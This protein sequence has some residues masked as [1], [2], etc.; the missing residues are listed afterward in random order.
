MA[1]QS[2]WIVNTTDDTFEADVFARSELGLVVVDFWAEWCAPCRMLGPVLEQLAID[3][4]GR[5]TLVKADTDQNQAAAG[6]FGVSGIP[7]VFAVLDRQVVDSF[8]GAL[9]P[10]AVK[11]WLESLETVATLVEANR[12]AHDDPHAAEQKIRGIL[13]TSPDFAPALIALA[14][15]L[16]GQDR[17]D[18]CGEIIARLEARGFLEPEAEAIKATL[19]LKSKASIDI[20]AARSAAESN[21]DDF[22]LQF[23]LAEAL[24]GHEQ[25]AE[26]FD[27]C[28]SLVERDRHNTGEKARALMVE[29]FHALPADAELV[30]DY[31]RRLSSL[32]Y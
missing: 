32:L 27:I 17:D 1:E 11:E 29:A 21:P 7:A 28:L 5:F 2:E 9:P 22:N 25:H 13:E 19:V 16:L 30:N 12:I 3:G 15:L 31:R 26:A 4:A 23:R 14:E 24:L 18:E 8:Q 6:Q 20:E 10:P